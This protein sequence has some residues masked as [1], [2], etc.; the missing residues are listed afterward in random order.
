[1]KRTL[2]VS[3]A[4][5]AA[6]FL[7]PLLT[8]GQ[9]KWTSRP[10]TETAET[11]GAVLPQPSADPPEPEEAPPA[12]FDDM[13]ISALINDLPTEMRLGDFIIG[14]VAAEMPALYPDEALKAQA[15]AVRTLALYAQGGVYHG[16]ALLCDNFACCLAYIDISEKK[17]DWGD[18]FEEFSSKISAAVSDT[19][20]AVILYRGE[21]IEALFFAATGGRT[22]SSAEVWGGDKPYLRSVE[23]IHDLDFPGEN[24]GHGVGMSQYGARQ[25][26][27]AGHSF[28]EILKWYYSGVEIYRH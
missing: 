1:M 10:E 6:V 28:E 12:F 21:P 27:L 9:E 19:D 26:A 4:L 3:A 13:I 5:Y 2:A 20:G 18:N 16:D 22:L 24:R 25:M 7:I 17:S 15:A 8:A 11:S 14:A 23:S